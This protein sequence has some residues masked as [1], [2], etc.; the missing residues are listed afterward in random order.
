MWRKRTTREREKWLEIPLLC[1]NTAGKTAGHDWKHNGASALYI[2]FYL[3]RDAFYSISFWFA[4][5]WRSFFILFAF[6]CSAAFFSL[7][8]AYTFFPAFFF[9]CGFT[10]LGNLNGVSSG[11]CLFNEGVA[12]AI[13]FFPSYATFSPLSL[14]IVVVVAWT[15]W[16]FVHWLV[17]GITWRFTCPFF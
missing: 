13:R 5:A 15:D 7:F 10:L 1:A 9:K 12:S 11:A 4:R 2:H 16:F 6:S 14:G 17:L 3:A 8:T